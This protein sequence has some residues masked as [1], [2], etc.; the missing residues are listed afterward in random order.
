M[1]EFPS[2]F[3][4]ARE[5]IEPV[6]SAHGFRLTRE[7]FEPE[8]FGS[9]YAEYRKEGS[10]LRLIWDGKDAW[11]WL[12]V[13]RPI[14]RPPSISDWHDLEQEQTGRPVHVFP[15]DADSFPTRIGQVHEALI[16]AIQA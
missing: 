7:C 1:R 12:S 9:A 6:L 15:V 2:A 16:L 5:Q 3:N 13:A 10:W 11:L 4:A 14:G 8:S